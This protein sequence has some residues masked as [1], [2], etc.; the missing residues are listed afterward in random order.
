MTDRDLFRL[1]E[2]AEP[3]GMTPSEWLE[4]CSPSDP[5]GMTPDEYRAALI[6]VSE[7]DH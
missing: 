4:I 1:V 6:G 2:L 3:L 7:E 5:E